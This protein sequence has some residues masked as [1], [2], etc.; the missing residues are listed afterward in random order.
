MVRGTAKPPNARE[1]VLML[2]IAIV[3]D[4]AEDVALIK[5]YIAQT[6]GK[7]NNSGGW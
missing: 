3:E 6:L 1:G 7:D 5:K 4:D 2:R